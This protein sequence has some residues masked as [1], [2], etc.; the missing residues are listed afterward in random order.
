M[1]LACFLCTKLV[2]NTRAAGAGRGHM[3]RRYNH[4]TRARRDQH[5]YEQYE[6]ISETIYEKKT[7]LKN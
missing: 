2:Q 3:T 7:L 6:T 5:K 1:F 4:T